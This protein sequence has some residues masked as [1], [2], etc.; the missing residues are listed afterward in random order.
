MT[1]AARKP[2]E[3]FEEQPEFEDPVLRGRRELMQAIASAPLADEEETEEERLFVE[4]AMRG[5]FTPGEAVTAEIAARCP[6][7]GA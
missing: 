5:P 6:R 3:S 1:S 7:P 4:E 2:A